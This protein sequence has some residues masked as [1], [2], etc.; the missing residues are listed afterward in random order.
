MGEIEKR[1][2]IT[3]TTKQIT[4]EGG[5]KVKKSQSQEMT[6]RVKWSKEKVRIGL[7]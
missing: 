5:G 6:Q 1:D 7:Q 3:Q 2:G 4:R